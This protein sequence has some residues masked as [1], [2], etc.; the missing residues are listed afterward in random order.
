VRS[1]FVVLGLVGCSYHPSANTAPAGDSGG[2][3]DAPI[4]V[5]PSDDRDGDGV[6]NVDDNCPD[7]ANS[8]QHDEDNDALG[9]PCDPCP[10]SADSTDSDADGVGDVCDPNPLTGGDKLLQFF[11]FQGSGGL[12]AGWIVRSGAASDWSVSGD[13]L[14]VGIHDTPDFITIEAG[15][16][17]THIEI[18]AVVVPS[19]T[20][21]PAL[22][23]VF[24][25]SSTSLFYACSAVYAGVA[26]D[27]LQEFSNNTFNPLASGNV[28]TTGAITI[29]GGLDVTGEH[30]LF[31]QGT[32]QSLTVNNATHAQSTVGIRVRNAMVDI[33][34]VAIY[35]SP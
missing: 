11:G 1:W 8:D 15:F 14:H 9:D 25:F 19:G 2:D 5:P 3:D 16:N 23:T 30:C 21:F 26:G 10:P 29:R 12:P 20:T 31:R 28:P 7:A 18:G 17:R 13:Q 32:A 24:D 35:Q 4:D 6:T 22:S 34:Y 27:F 33:H